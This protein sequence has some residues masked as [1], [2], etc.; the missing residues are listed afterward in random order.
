MTS[1]KILSHIPK[2]N[3]S[4]AAI[5]LCASL[6]AGCTTI[7]SLSHKI[8]PSFHNSPAPVV[9]PQ[10]P[11]RIYGDDLHAYAIPKPPDIWPRVRDGFQLPDAPTEERITKRL[12]WLAKHPRHVELH[13]KRGSIYLHYILERLDQQH[14]PYELALIPMVESGFD[15]FAY[16][17]ANAAGMWQFMP[18]TGKTLGL[19]QNWWYDG[20]RDVAAATDAAITYLTRLHALFDNDWLLAIAAY[21]AGEG[22]LIKAIKKN[23][24][25]GKPIDFWSLDLPQQTQKYVPKILALKEVIL[26]PDIYNI[27][28]PA[29]ANTP[30][31]AITQLDSQI[32]LAQAAQMAEINIE[33]IHNLNPGFNRWAT[34]PDGPHCLIVPSTNFDRFI[35]A[36]ENIPAKDRVT[37][38]RY[39]V[40]NGDTLGTIAQKYGVSIRL[41][42]SIN[43]L[44][45]NT[46]HT[47]K[48][49]LVPKSESGNLAYALS[50]RQHLKAQQS[51][52]KSQ[53]IA[54]KVTQ[55]DSL[56]AIAKRFKVSTQ[57]IA[58]WNHLAKNATLRLGQTLK[59]QQKIMPQGPSR[60]VQHTI[61][62]GDSLARIA[63]KYG[64]K[65]A[66]LERWNSIKRSHILKPG[67]TLTVHVNVAETST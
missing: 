42:Q 47:S 11:C 21:N 67:K 25:A 36:L 63:H 46:I 26:R 8:S 54:Y 3:L 62:S 56:W 59:I 34:A 4:N 1:H 39:T 60:K 19:Q 52:N 44:N 66:D 43:Q 16:S 7:D 45:G 55:G 35:A 53:S 10:D 31:F 37:W 64:V 9:Q 40:K 20:R 50:T 27:A 6:L 18:G 12:A 13:A 65:I 41:L 22:N 38:E 15:P 49:L 2:Y 24:R 57:E 51:A 29:I 32:D 14:L 33:E 30:Y 5:A 61:K 48:T 17:Y 23:K 28:L 58:Q